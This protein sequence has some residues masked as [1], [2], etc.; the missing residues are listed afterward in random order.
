[1]GKGI[2]D[3][4]KAKRIEKVLAERFRA[5]TAKDG[6]IVLTMKHDGV[7]LIITPDWT[8]GQIR[9]PE[10]ANMFTVYVDVPEG[11]AVVRHM[12]SDSLLEMAVRIANYR[13]IDLNVDGG[14]IRLMNT[15]PDYT[16]PYDMYNDEQLKKV[17]AMQNSMEE[18]WEE[19]DFYFI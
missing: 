12:A 6:S 13:G 9:I 14:T 5:S 8:F 19:E 3:T 1:M 7:M 15:A 16:F 2:H 10:N 18:E 17:Q 4:T 11:R